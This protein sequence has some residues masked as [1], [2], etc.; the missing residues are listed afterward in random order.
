MADDRCDGGGI[1][2]G[3]I[4]GRASILAHFDIAGRVGEID[5]EAPVRGVAGMKGETK[6]TTFAA[7]DRVLRVGNV[8]KYRLARPW[9]C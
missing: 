8:E 9:P 6:H 2:H 1:G 7:V 3:G 4:G 5:E